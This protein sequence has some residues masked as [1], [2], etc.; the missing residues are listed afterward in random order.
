MRKTE[1]AALL[2][3]AR[4]S[5]SLAEDAGEKTGGNL[6]FIVTNRDARGVYRFRVERP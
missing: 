4:P 2:L 1:F 6:P 3:F 5:A